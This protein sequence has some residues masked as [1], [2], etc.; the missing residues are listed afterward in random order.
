MNGE[1]LEEADYLFRKMVR[2][3]VKERDKIIIEGITLPALL[4]LRKISRE[5]GQ[6]L[7]DLAEQ[8]DFTSGAITALCD[9]LEEK[10][11][12]IRCK[13]EDRRTV[14]LAI[15]DEGRAMC[16][17]HQNI[18]SRCITVLFAGFSEAELSA[19]IKGYQQIFGNLE[20][21]SSAILELAR[22][23]A[24]QANLANQKRKIDQ[25][26]RKNKFLSY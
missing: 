18:G 6:R 20:S 14:L 16:L 10:G 26:H 17:R 15:T 21:F 2:R 3:F 12:A 24:E 1:M 25:A 5:G 22:E 4:I 23:N 7:G 19:Q 8:L 13:G 9:K 11:F